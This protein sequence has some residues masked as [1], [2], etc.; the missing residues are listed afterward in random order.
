MC[1]GQLCVENT[2]LIIAFIS[3][4]VHNISFCGVRRCDGNPSDSNVFQDKCRKRLCDVGVVSTVGLCRQTTHSGYLDSE[5]ALILFAV[6]SSQVFLKCWSN[7][8][9]MENVCV[10]YPSV[11]G[12]FHVQ[13][14]SW[15]ISCTTVSTI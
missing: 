1:A 8:C 12:A 11:L 10:R 13:Q 14:L 15:G 9:T 6:V 7:P 2:V 5:I 4:E 3:D